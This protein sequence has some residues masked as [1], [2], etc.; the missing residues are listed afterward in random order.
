LDF[1]SVT[2][3]DLF[4]STLFSY[5][6]GARGWELAA[7]GGLG[8]EFFPSQGGSRR[9][10]EGEGI[11][12]TPEGLPLG[13]AFGGLASFPG[14]PTRDNWEKDVKV[15]TSQALRQT[16]SLVR[17]QLRKAVLEIRLSLRSIIEKEEEYQEEVDALNYSI[18]EVRLS[19]L[20]TDRRRLLVP[21]SLAAPDIARLEDIQVVLPDGQEVEGRF[22]GALGDYQAFWVET[23]TDLPPP[24]DG[25]TRLDPLASAGKDSGPEL[26]S[27]LEQEK[28]LFL[29]FFVSFDLGRRREI[30]DT[31]RLLGFHHGYR[32][33]PLFSTLT[34]ELPTSLA[35]SPDGEFLAL[36]L[37][38]RLPYKGVAEVFDANAAFLPWPHLARQ[39]ALPTAVDTSL[40]PVPAARG[41]RLIDLGVE[42][43][44]LDLNISRLFLA[45]EA[46][47]GG[48][49]GLLVNH[50]YPGT[51]AE[52]LGIREQDIILSL[53][54]A[55]QTEAIELVA[56]D[57]DN[58]A[59]EHL[60]QSDG[61]DFLQVWL[62]SL[63]PPWP[64][65]ENTLSLLLT[66]LGS[67]RQVEVEYWR[68][69]ELARGVFVTS[70][71]EEDFRNARK[72]RVAS[73]GI[74]VKPLTYEAVRYLR[75]P[76][77]EGVLV[78]DVEEG[79]LGQV[80]G[81]YPCLLITRV[82][83]LPLT[84]MAD[85]QDKL[86]AFEADKERVVELTLEGFGKTRLVKMEQ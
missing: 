42:W 33:A 60:T 46:T 39:F 35:F 78:A 14:L 68:E 26:T 62:S 52:Q 80:A 36:T 67:G 29:R 63:S 43:Q 9:E 54:V 27:W 51:S 20:V 37:A 76:G 34:N 56:E 5:Y 75:R 58:G 73:L 53:K 32:D 38:P 7:G 84:D 21:A 19:G 17:S 85:F 48:K 59:W 23:R 83:G 61:E 72:W 28:G 50:V 74:S 15:V 18:H 66:S 82:N 13:L 16:E 81:I 55:G 71:M 25:F 8:R 6:Y 77:P 79:S 70:F 69:G 11:L 44:G 4:D 47:R 12:V 10:V 45:E 57:Y 64:S 86:A 31:D 41:R 49:I 24:L 2:D 22:A 65:R 1:Q 3:L 30:A 40:I